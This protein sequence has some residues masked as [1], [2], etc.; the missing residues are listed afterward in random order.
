MFS[1]LRRRS[2]ALLWTG[3]LISVAGDWVLHAALPFYVY[4]RTGSTLATAGMIVAE[5][6]PHVLLGTVAGVFVDRWDRRA[7][8][9]ATNLAQALT[10][11][12]LFVVSD[13]GWLWLI[14]VVAAVQSSLA[15]F[16][17]PA[18]TSLVPALVE[19]EHLVS[20]NALNGLNNRLA[21]LLGLP[22]GGALLATFG[23]EAVITVDLVSFL[24]AALLI[25]GVQVP[26]RQTSAAAS[27]VA[28]AAAGAFASVLADWRAGLRIIRTRPQIRTVMVILGIATFGG[29][30][31]DP[32]VA[33]WVSDELG[34]NAATY[35]LLMTT[36]AVFGIVSSVLI[37]RWGKRLTPRTMMGWGSLTAGLIS[38]VKYNVPL[39]PVAYGLNAGT[40][41]TSVASSI[42]IDTHVQ[43]VVPTDYQGR[44]FGALGAT[45]A[46]LS[47]SGAGVGGIGGEIFGVV[48]MLTVAAL[49]IVLS[50]IIVLR[51]LPAGPEP[52]ASVP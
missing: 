1:L 15:A 5:L 18:E 3:G 4:Q 17:G 19:D 20:A 29:T 44:V 31:L 47:L 27:D 25:A 13:P 12:A 49:L 46:L 40:G 6:V 7:I 52:E 36:H 38:L 26:L 34:A 24:V 32:L 48:P 2:F 30:M 35:S 41:M 42:G 21:R 37:G 14:Y 8:L 9:V 23:L 16:A 11:G 39:V 33:A 51:A 43:R 28:D 45:G 22:L 50:G 10:V